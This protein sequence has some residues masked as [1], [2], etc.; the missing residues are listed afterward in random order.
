MSPANLGLLGSTTPGMGAVPPA[1]G[2]VALVT[3]FKG[4]LF[5]FIFCG[6]TPP[7]FCNAGFA[8]FLG[9]MLGRVNG[10]Y[11]DVD[12]PLFI[13]L[14][15]P[16]PPGAPIFRFMSVDGL[17]K[18]RELFAAGDVPATMGFD[19]GTLLVWSTPAVLRMEGLCA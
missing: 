19:M 10:R 6:P 9:S 18:S 11:D 7:R 2:V 4:G 12:W 3:S 16:P 14:P 8:P 5:P 13:G 15:N 17:T 1:P